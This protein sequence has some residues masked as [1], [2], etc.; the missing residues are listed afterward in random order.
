MNR[1][2]EHDPPAP[3]RLADRP[4][5]RRAYGIYTYGLY[6]PA[7][8][9]TTAGFGSAAWL[10]ATLRRGRMADRMGVYWAR[11]N[12]A[13]APMRVTVEGR[14]NAVPGQSYV[15]VAN[16]QSQ[17]DI[18]ALYG[19]LGLDFRWVMKQELRNVPF[20]G[21]AC[22]RI[23]HVFIDRSNS[24]AAR[25]S[26]SAAREQLRGGT[27]ILFF[28]EGTRSL[29][30]RLLPFRKGAFHLALELGLP[31]LPV[32]VVGTRHILPPRTLSLFPGRA[33]LVVHPPIEARGD[34]AEPAQDLLVRAR[35]AIESALPPA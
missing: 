6:L 33:K 18:F 20:L 35:A 7:L 3:R 13:I 28:P 14:E 5:L 24:E 22:H 11:V 9:V 29:D 23:G 21:P 12:A 34:V 10:L 30:G 27:S 19:W 4:A 15:I 1:A 16:H 31:V 32:S 25:A 26:I 2:S 8:G 17:F